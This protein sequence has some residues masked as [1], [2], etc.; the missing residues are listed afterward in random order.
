[1]AAG[2]PGGHECYCVLLLFEHGFENLFGIFAEERA[3]IE[4]MEVQLAIVQVCLHQHRV[5][6]LCHGKIPGNQ[7]E[8]RDLHMQLGHSLQAAVEAGDMER[9]QTLLTEKNRYKNQ[10]PIPE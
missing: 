8:T 7:V 6:V 9:F 10:F 4:L 2:G 3:V 1:M 5:A